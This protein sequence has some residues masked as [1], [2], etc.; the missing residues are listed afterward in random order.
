MVAGT[1][2]LLHGTNRPVSPP[3]FA[4]PPSRH[5]WRRQHRR[6]RILQC[7]RKTVLAFQ[8][9]LPSLKP[10]LEELTN[11][12]QLTKRLKVLRNRW[13]QMQH[14]QQQT[15]R[16][17]GSNGDSAADSNILQD[18]DHQNDTDDEELALWK[19]IMVET[20]TRMVTACYIVYTLLFLSLT[21]QIH[22]IG[23][24]LMMMMEGE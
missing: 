15:G 14:K 8:G 12:S 24:R 6:E 17:Q 2:T 22:W 16:L 4:G 23:S 19:Q 11:T 7:R 10:V 13:Q 1:S 20:T 3:S 5:H 9:F 21:V 18:E